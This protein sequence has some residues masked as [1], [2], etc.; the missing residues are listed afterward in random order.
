MHLRRVSRLSPPSSRAKLQADPLHVSLPP[1]PW[2]WVKSSSKERM[3]V[4]PTHWLAGVVDRSVKE[5]P[6]HGEARSI[7]MLSSRNGCGAPL[8]ASKTRSQ[9]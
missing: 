3:R 4:E 5:R 9:S 1:Q 2:R 8:F 7:G 6:Q